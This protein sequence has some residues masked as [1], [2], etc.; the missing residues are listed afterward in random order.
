MAAPKTAIQLY[1]LRELDEPLPTLLDRVA[2][3]GYDGVEFATPVADIGEETAATLDRTGLEV[4]G[5]H[6]DCEALEA[7]PVALAE[8][9]SELDC[10]R[11]VVPW[12]DPASF[13]TRT[14]TYR[15]AVR[16][17]DLAADLRGTD[18]DLLYHNHTGEFADVGA[19][20]AFSLLV[21]ATAGVDFEL[22]LGW[23]AAAGY[24]P[25]TVVRRFGSR[26]PLLHVTD[27]DGDGNCAEL[28]TGRVDLPAC[29]EAARDAGCEWFVYEY[30]DPEDPLDSLAHGAQE[31]D[32]LLAGE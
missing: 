22:D 9:W 15:T 23:A 24:D 2:D 5:A 8:R 28:R 30:D 17:S 11:L 31:L 10:S 12:L 19:A 27:V 3:A 1:T 26:V 21:P 6:V 7:D 20:S 4:V 32:R 29:V 18:A 14:E 13:A 16:L 25:A